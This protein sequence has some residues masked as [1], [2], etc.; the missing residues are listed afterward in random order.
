MKQHIVKLRTRD[1]ALVMV[2]LALVQA[3]LL[4]F[5][6]SGSSLAWGGLAA[7]IRL[8]GKVL[9][10]SLALTLCIGIVGEYRQKV[11]L[12]F[13][14]ICLAIFSGVS[15]IRYLFDTQVIEAFY[16][17]YWHGQWITVLREVPAAISLMFL[18]GGVI[19]MAVALLRTGLGFS[20]RKVD[21]GAMTVVFVF[22]LLVLYLRND[23]SAVSRLQHW[24]PRDA[25]LAS[26]IFFCV[27]A[28]GAIVLLRL[29]NQMGGG[30][31]AA[32]MVWI[33]VHIGTRAAL[34]L[35]GPFEGH[36]AFVPHL[37]FIES[38]IYDCTPWMFA[39]AAACRYQ[40]TANATDQ[41]AEWGVDW[42]SAFRNSPSS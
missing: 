10:Y 29:S 35:V 8:V 12:R 1:L 16:P 40:L 20:L 39:M 27:T 17:G 28:A 7:I 15:V 3:V 32:A 34:V 41:V 19:L 9:A 5:G 11:W 24:L 21:I 6:I 33:I 31:L 42:V 38:V 4:L 25:Q 26:N 23:M 30:Q 18:A 2:L 36:L 22:L 13:A 14:W 37:K